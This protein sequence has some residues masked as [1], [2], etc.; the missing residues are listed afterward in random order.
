[1]TR[2]YLI[3][4]ILAT[5]MLLL[6]VGTSLYSQSTNST[7]TPVVEHSDVARINLLKIDGVKYVTHGSTGY[8]DWSHAVNISLI[9][10]KK[11]PI[12]MQP[13]YL[14]GEMDVY[15]K[16]WI[17]YNMDGD[18]DDLYEYACYGKGTGT[19]YG[20]L[21]IPKDIKNGETTMRVAIST[22]HYPTVPCDYIESGEVED[23][24]V[25]ISEGSQIVMKDIPRGGLCVHM[26]SSASEKKSD[27]N[28]EPKRK[29]KINTSIA[30]TEVRNHRKS[31]DYK[32]SIYPNPSIVYSLVKIDL[33]G[34]NQEI[35]K[36]IIT[37]VSGKQIE[38]LSYIHMSDT[39]Y[40]LNTQNIP[41][42]M[43]NVTAYIGDQ[44]FSTKLLIAK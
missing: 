10:G 36:I 41:G 39:S 1:M 4:G 8:Y 26:P 35:D 44:P 33:S 14:K 13:Q 38:K 23:Y 22:D 11:Y 42:G 6:S 31:T 12:R 37:D 40:R 21:S 5:T 9:A 19:I 28:V 16:I 15:W 27:S 7:C 29:K 17:D 32:L 18:F 43:Y 2:N 34:V 30:K 3:R 25:T 20:N 24:K